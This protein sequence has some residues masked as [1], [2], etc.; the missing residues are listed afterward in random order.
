MKIILG[1]RPPIYSYTIFMYFYLFNSVRE[2]STSVKYSFSF[3][4]LLTDNSR[5]IRTNNFVGDKLMFSLCSVPFV[6]IM[7]IVLTNSK[8][9]EYW[10]VKPKN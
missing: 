1:C 3:I 10:T 2:T 5:C 7:Q 4:A 6:L 9:F 8:L